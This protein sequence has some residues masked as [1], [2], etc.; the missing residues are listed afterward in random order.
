MWQ[1]ALRAGKTAQRSDTRRACARAS[2][3]RPDDFWAHW[4]AIL[5]LHDHVPAVIEDT[6]DH[7]GGQRK[8]ATTQYWRNLRGEKCD[9]ARL[10]GFGDAVLTALDD[11]GE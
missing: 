11:G 5:R 9:S 3:R 4:S 7:D 8:F 2:E 10:S 1:A 6:H